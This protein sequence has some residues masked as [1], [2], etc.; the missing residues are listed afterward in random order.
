[1]AADIA[2]AVGAGAGARR[3]RHQ[4]IGYWMLTELKLNSLTDSVSV[5][6]WLVD[7]FQ[8]RT[9]HVQLAPLTARWLMVDIINSNWW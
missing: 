9:S 3:L 1:M 4:G 6:E 2:A 7:L 5:S 8:R